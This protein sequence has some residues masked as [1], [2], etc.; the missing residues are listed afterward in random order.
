MTQDI[1]EN[2]IEVIRDFFE[3]DDIFVVDRGFRDC[4]TY[5]ESLRFEA[6]MPSF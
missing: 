6:K 5:L 1:L 2:N 3:Y 4:L